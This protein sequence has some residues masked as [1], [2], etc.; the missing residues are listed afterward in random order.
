[1]REWNYSFSDSLTSALDGFEWSAS[2]P[3]RF[4]PRKEIPVPINRRLGW[5]QIQ[6]GNYKEQYNRV[7]LPG[8]EP[9]I[10]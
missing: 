2:R 10:I 9:V 3:G 7:L 8:F 6:Y 4:T 5:A 1:M